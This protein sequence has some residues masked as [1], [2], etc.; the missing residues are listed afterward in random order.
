MQSQKRKNSRPKTNS[1]QS[2]SFALDELH[3]LSYD[4]H[5]NYIRGIQNVTLDDIKHAA[6]KYFIPGGH[7]IV[8]AGPKP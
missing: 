2:L 5:E 8:T 3:G 1:D 6:E 7:V 4:L